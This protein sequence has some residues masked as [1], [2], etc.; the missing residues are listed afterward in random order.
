[1]SRGLFRNVVFWDFWIFENIFGLILGPGGGKCFQK[2]IWIVRN[3]GKLLEKN[4]SHN[5]NSKIY[6]LQSLP[7]NRYD[8][9]KK[10]VTILR[11]FEF[12]SIF[13]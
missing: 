10:N 13:S 1:M 8:N 2:I 4:L 5:L 9:I 7:P 11:S 12:S 6:K 3:F